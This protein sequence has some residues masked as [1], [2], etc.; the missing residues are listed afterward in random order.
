MVI[1]DTYKN[2]K[3]PSEMRLNLE[4]IAPRLLTLVLGV[5]FLSLSACGPIKK[6]ASYPTEKAKGSDKMVYTDDKRETIWGPDETL[7]SK[8]FG[9]DKDKD[10]GNGIGVNSFLWSAA[11]NTISFMPV[12]SADPFGG[13]ILTDWYENPETPGE[14]FKLNVYILDR[15]L[16]ADGVRV[17]AFKQ[18]LHNGQWR[19]EKIS[20][21]MADNIENIILTRARELRVAAL[22]TARK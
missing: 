22:G 10:S 14:R 12:A 2:D 17:S 6:E 15:K 8:I 4:N 11:L 5:C 20:E 3:E 19:D 21:G 7:S 16:R 1:K 9:G 18:K 13:V